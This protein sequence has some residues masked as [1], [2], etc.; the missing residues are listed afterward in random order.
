MISQHKQSC[1]IN[2]SFKRKLSPLVSYPGTIHQVYNSVYNKVYNYSACI[3]SFCV[4]L[5]LEGQLAHQ[6][7]LFVPYRPLKCP[8][9]LI[10]EDDWFPWTQNLRQIPLGDTNFSQNL[11][12]F[13]ELHVRQALDNVSETITEL[14]K[15]SITSKLWTVTCVCTSRA[16]QS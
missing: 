8:F 13:L 7:S 9:P 14:V 16:F 15:I 2:K 11:K 4:P 1:K 5:C 6:K 3:L 12:Q 10:F